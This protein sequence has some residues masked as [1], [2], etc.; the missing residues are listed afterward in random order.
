[1]SFLVVDQPSAYNIIIGRPTLNQLKAI[2]STYHL[3]V[4]FP[5]EKRI[6][7]MLGDQSM[8]RMCY[9]QGVDGKPAEKRVNTTTRVI[10]KTHGNSGN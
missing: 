10:K 2:T 1:M 6:A 4:K 3:M 8:A 5:T 9:I 7:I